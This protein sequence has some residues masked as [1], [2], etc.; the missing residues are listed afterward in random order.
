MIDWDKAELSISIKQVHEIA[1]IIDSSC[2]SCSNCRLDEF[3]KTHGNNCY[4][5]F[6]DY[7]SQFIH[8][9]KIMY[10]SLDEISDKIG[11]SISVCNDCQIQGF[12]NN[13]PDISLCSSTWQ[14]WLLK[15][16]MF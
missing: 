6:I 12:C 2:L 5:C 13:H 7:I 14:S 4:E 10:K 1:R 15:K 9:G 8:D 16:I 11:L 3:C